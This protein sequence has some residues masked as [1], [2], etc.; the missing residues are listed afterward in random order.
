MLII[1][2]Q[3]GINFTV[4]ITECRPYCEGY[5]L[6]EKLKKEGIDCKVIID[7]AV[8]YCLEDIEFVLVGA[9]GIVENGGILNR[10]IG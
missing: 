1:A 9:E 2:H 5:A 3:K 10:V 7:S 8:A 4:Y 6:Y